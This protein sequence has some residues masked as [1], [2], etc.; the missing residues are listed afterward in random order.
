[1]VL[2]EVYK[3]MY[4]ER[5]EDAAD[6]VAA[7]MVQSE[8]LDLNQPVALAAAVFCKD[9]KLATADA[10]VLAHAAVANLPL[11]TFDHHFEKLPGVHYQ[12]TGK[13]RNLVL[14]VR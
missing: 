3:W 9:L 2:L 12:A 4:R 13:R 14:T 6:L 10:T 8:L 5:G 1:M 11:V 7:R